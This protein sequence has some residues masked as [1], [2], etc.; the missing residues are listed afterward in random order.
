MPRLKALPTTF[1]ALVNSERG[2]SPKDILIL[3]PRRLLGYKIRDRIEA[4]E[5]SVHSFYHEEAL[6][7]DTAQ[8][9]FALL[10]LLSNM[11]DRVSLRWWLGHD[12]ETARAKAYKILREHCEKA[13]VGPREALE[14][15]RA[16]S[17]SLPK[18][19]ELVAKYK[20]LVSVIDRL[21]SLSV[22]DLVGELLPE[23]DEECAVLREAALQLPAEVDSAASLFEHI[24]SSATQPDVPVDVDYVRVMSLHKSKGL[25]SK[26]A[27]VT[28]CSHGLVP[29]FDAD[30]TPEEQAITLKEQR[31]LFYVAITRCTEILTISSVTRMEKKLAYKVGAKIR[32]QY[33]PSGATVANRF[34]D[35]LGPTAPA[36]V[37]GSDWTAIGF[38]L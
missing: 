30:E 27:I 7:G 9:A 21:S 22:Q 23:G 20:E 11:D 8:R 16:G 12:S 13:G 4:H 6:E 19:E 15:L 34:L 33:G 37:R 25:T 32:F 17:L 29:Y 2:I 14:Q 10:S 1:L 18:T 38:N 3:T 31:R 5:I 24:K 26:V 28:A 36:A 35:E